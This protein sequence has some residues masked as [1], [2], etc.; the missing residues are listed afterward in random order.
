MT[1]YELRKFREQRRI[2]KGLSDDADEARRSIGLTAQMDEAIRTGAKRNS[3]LEKAIEKYDK[4]EA[5]YVSTFIQY[6]NTRKKIE[7]LLKKLT[8]NEAAVIRLYYING[9][10]W[11]QTAEKLDY[12]TRHIYRI[13]GEALKKLEKIKK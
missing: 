13:H 9:L 5:D 11:E 10:T 7:K 4:I 12:E 6:A 1:K 8:A 3:A 2:L